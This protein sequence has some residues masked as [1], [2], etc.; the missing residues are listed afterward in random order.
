MIPALICF[1][2][3]SGAQSETPMRFFY[4]WVRQLQLEKLLLG[5]NFSLEPIWVKFVRWWVCQSSSQQSSSLHVEKHRVLWT[6][7]PNEEI[8]AHSAMWLFEG[9]SNDILQSG[10]SFFFPLF[11][12]EIAL[13]AVKSGFPQ[14]RKQSKVTNNW[15][16][17]NFSFCGQ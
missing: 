5:S 17:W 14:Y 3:G 10:I 16:F 15:K 1:A 12:L 7:F 6:E 8:A 4:F 9:W 2:S 13:R 11:N